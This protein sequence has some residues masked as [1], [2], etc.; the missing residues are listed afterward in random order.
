MDIGPMIADSNSAILS[1]V[2]TAD[3]ENAP[4]SAF[5]FYIFHSAGQSLDLDR[6]E[7]NFV[8]HFLTYLHGHITVMIIILDFD[9]Y[10]LAFFC[11][12]N[13]QFFNIRVDHGLVFIRIFVSDLVI[14]GIQGK[15]M[16]VNSEDVVIHVY[17]SPGDVGRNMKIEFLITAPSVILNLDR[18]LGVGQVDWR[19]GLDQGVV[20]APLSGT[21]SSNHFLPPAHIK[22]NLGQFRV[23]SD[24]GG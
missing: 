10:F 24:T 16:T 3:V 23:I 9:P 21:G 8:T 14:L 18:G 17:G 2:V 15:T 13:T 11:G 4:S 19:L 5:A 20:P 12:V 7:I 1:K 6:A 22:E